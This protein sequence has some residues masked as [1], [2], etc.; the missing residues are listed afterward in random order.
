MVAFSSPQANATLSGTAEVSV[1]ASDS[2]GIASVQLYVD[3][4]SLGMMTLSGSSYVASI[5]TS[6][7]SNGSHELK[8]VVTDTGG[9]VGQGTVAVTVQNAP[10]VPTVSFVSPAANATLSGTATVTVAA[11]DTLGIAQVNL[12][13]DN[14]LVGPMNLS[15]SSYVAS[16]STGAYSNGSHQLKA[17]ATDRGGNQ[18]QS[19]LAVSIANAQLPSFFI[20]AGGPNVTY[21]GTSWIPDGP[22]VSGSAL[23]FSNSHIGGNPVY[24]TEHYGNMK[25]RFSVPNGQYNVVLKFAE[26]FFTSSHQRIFNVSINGQQVITK[27]DVFAKAGFGMPYDLTF[28]VTVTN[29]TIAIQFTSVINYAKVNGIQI[30]PN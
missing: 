15:G 2:L 16:I 7:L 26:I 23:I 4:T 5:N 9:N 29:G 22:Y 11:A 21:Q 13:V 18:G 27:L 17:I 24:Q 30:V 14:T 12:Y 19:T 28:P 3:S 6:Q 10:T 1:Q 25:Y 8:A 20:N